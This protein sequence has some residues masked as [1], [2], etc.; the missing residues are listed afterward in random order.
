MIA[1]LINSIA[2]WSVA[3]QAFPIQDSSRASAQNGPSGQG[4]QARLQQQRLGAFAQY[5]QLSD[6]QKRQFMQIQRETGQSVR[7]ARHDDTLSEELMQQKI[8]QIHAQQRER[9]LALLRPEQQALLKKWN[10]EQKQKQTQTG[11]AGQSTAANA[12]KPG[13]PSGTDDDFFAGMVQDPD[14]PAAPEQPQTRTGKGPG[15]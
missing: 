1:V 10:E 8:K 2:L 11:S 15:N 6:D 12:G 4:Q 13:D 3:A 9:I 7:A 5:L 14:P